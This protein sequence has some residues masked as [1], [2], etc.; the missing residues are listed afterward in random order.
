[1]ELVDLPLMEEEVKRMIL[2][3]EGEKVQSLM[4]FILCSL[5][6]CLYKIVFKLLTNRLKE[7][8][9][10]IISEQQSAFISGRNMLDSVL[11]ANEVFEYVRRHNKRCFVLK[12]DYEKAYDLVEWGYILFMLCSFGFSEKWVHIGR[13]LKQGIFLPFFFLA[14]AEGLGVLIRKAVAY[15]LFFGVKI[16]VGVPD[17]F[18]LQ[19]ADDIL[20]MGDASI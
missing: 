7:V 20:I 10:S 2:E 1:M 15:E 11:V 18:L 12:F 14:A 4:D 5:R 13:G 9:N 16:V 6:G 17:I 19:F 3:Y 8:M